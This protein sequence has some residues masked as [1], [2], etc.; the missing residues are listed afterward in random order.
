MSKRF[1]LSRVLA[2]AV[3][4]G[5]VSAALAADSRKK[6]SKARDVVDRVR[7]PDPPKVQPRTGSPSA[8]EIARRENALEQQRQR[9][10]ARRRG[11][12]DRGNVPSPRR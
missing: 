4:L 12:I 10:R 2:G 3:A 5:I 6:V 11:P 7:L 8:A 9:E 1:L